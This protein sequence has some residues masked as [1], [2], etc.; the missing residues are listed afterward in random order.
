VH[1]FED[2]VEAAGLIVVIVEIVKGVLL[3]GTIDQNGQFVAGL[4][5]EIKAIEVP[6]DIGIVPDPESFFPLR[7]Y[8]PV[9]PG[10]HVRT[11][12]R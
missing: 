11:P 2:D 4:D 12:E 7:L 5:Y 3:D 10:L 1:G 8:G 9:A 6:E